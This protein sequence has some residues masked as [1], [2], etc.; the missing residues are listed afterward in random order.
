MKEARKCSMLVD[1]V[2]ASCSAAHKN[3]SEME[4]GREKESEREREWKRQREGEREK[5]EKRKRE[6]VCRISIIY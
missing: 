5:G 2:C 6:I 4:N 3:E 1:N